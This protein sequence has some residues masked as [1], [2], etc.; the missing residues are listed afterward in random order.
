M[1]FN[2]IDFAIF[3]PIVFCLYW[4][5]V[6]KN[7]Q[8][9]NFLLLVASYVFYGWWDWRFLSLIAFS[10]LVDYSLGVLLGKEEKETKR[11]VYLWTSIIVN[12]GFL[13]FF[14]YYN[15][16]VESFVDAFTFFGQEIE[17]GTLNIIL[18]VGISFYT[19]QTLS[20]TI[21]VYKR[22]LEPTKK[23]IAFAAFVSF[24]PQ[25]VA[26]PIERASNLLPQILKK[27]SFNYCEAK[28]GLRLMLW[29]L[30]KKVVIADSLS[31]IV[32]DIF[33]NYSTLSSPVLIMGAIFFAFQIY[34]DFSGY[35]DIAIG[36]A[37]LFGIE[38]MSNFKFPYFSKNIGEFWRRWHISLSTWFRDYL[39]I[40]L[41]GSR[42]SKLK[43]IRNVFAI[44]IVSG[45]WHGANWTF[46]FWG[47]F[48]ALLFLPSFILG[49]NRKYVEIAKSGFNIVTA[50][51]NV[52]RT[53]LTFAL[54]TVGWVF[55]RAETI[56]DAFTYLKRIVTVFSVGD[57]SHPNGYRLID[58]LL[59]L[60]FFVA[61][62][63]II[64]N[65]ERNPISF[66]NKYVRL[67]VYILLVFLM[68]LFYDDGV[69]RSFIYFQF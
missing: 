5:V 9:Q 2:S 47:L 59:L 14:K 62:E 37:K 61:Y 67:L 46:I 66:K 18:P 24:F 43:G 27:R 10:T 4:V 25:L 32:N 63:Y 31:P 44:F 49:T 20:Y 21:D 45:F 23:F 7:L 39:Y 15:F 64:R 41:G 54:V 55:F 69:D 34:G 51:K 52:Y 16:F 58:Y 36:T 3:L 26:G 60:L 68:L 56:S 19:F 28:D 17:I 30:F 40:P 50:I 48:H 38:L 13:G 65:K 11:K 12:L 29:G 1:L 33:S 42:G 35:S 57:Y 22:N 6:N 53:V 8:L